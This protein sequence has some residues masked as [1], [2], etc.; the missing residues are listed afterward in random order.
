MVHPH[1]EKV[2]N[3]ITRLKDRFGWKRKLG[4][5]AASFFL[6]AGAL[7]WIMLPLPKDH[8]TEIP[9]HPKTYEATPVACDCFGQT[10]NRIQIKFTPSAPAQNN[11]PAYQIEEA[12]RE[13]KTIIYF[14]NVSKLNGDFKYEEII[15][16]PLIDSIDYRIDNRQLIIEI[17]RKGP[18]LP[19]Q[20]IA[21]AATATIVLFP[22]TDSYPLISNQ[23]P[24]DN[25]MVYPMQYTVSFEAVLKSP[26]KDAVAIFQG[27]P[28]DLKTAE[29]APNKYRFSFN[30]NI[31]ID[32]EYS[33]KAIVADQN[34]RTAVSV[35][36]F[37]GQIPSAAAL[38]KDR[39]KYLGWW[40]QINTNGVTVRKGMAISSEKIGTLSTANR[41]KVLKEGYGD[42]IDGKNLWYQIDGGAYPG[43][44]IF[45]DFITPMA[46]PQ[47]PQKFA[48]P[49]NVKTGEK[50]IDVDLT[51][52]V[53]TLFN[54][55]KPVFA[56]YIAPGRAENPTQ[57]G[58]Y[59]VWYKLI[60]AEMQGGPPLHSYRYHLKNIPWVMYYNY[61]YAIH[62]TYWHD[63][64]GTQQSA[65]CTNMTQ[66]DAK[67]IFDNTLP[68]IPDGKQFAVARGDDGLGTGT[69]VYNHE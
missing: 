22:A 59:R 53:M 68:A 14:N 21:D 44:Y 24:T 29:I 9:A 47:P 16:S 10:G 33:V 61:S 39:F 27:K 25:S 30:Q 5:A 66:G 48:I 2:R 38:G 52:K 63:K 40:G 18:Y 19:A 51:K 7:W 32:K 57:T 4:I 56:T 11:I 46:Q 15:G 43:A 34:G 13:G 8:E 58:T 26:L 69:V 65:G 1:L 37:S 55:D 6:I 49:E 35:W 54:Y 60:K 36:N 17:G 62:G 64:F 20:I 67:F 31:E 41:V 12:T 45:S 50:W 28:I 3:K 23:K 42:W